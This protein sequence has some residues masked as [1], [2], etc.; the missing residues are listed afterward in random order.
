MFL[1]SQVFIHFASPF[2][3]DLFLP[4]FFSM[5]KVISVMFPTTFFLL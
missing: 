1:Y 5:R 4:H 2:V 3:L